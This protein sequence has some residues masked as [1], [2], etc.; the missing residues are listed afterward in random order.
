MSDRLPTSASN[1]HRRINCP[2]SERA[3]IGL[4]NEDTEFSLQ[5]TRLHKLFEL[6]K[7]EFEAVEGVAEDELN[8]VTFA[9]NLAQ[10]AFLAIVKNYGIAD[11][12]PYEQGTERELWVHVGFK[13]AI[14]GHCDIWRYYPGRKLLVILD[15]KFGFIEVDAAPV[16][17][18]LRTYAI[19]GSEEW[20]VEDCAVG[21]IQPRAPL[22]DGAEKITLAT[23]TR[24]SIAEA[25][26]QLLAYREAWMEKNAPIIPSP[27]ACRY[28]KAVTVCK[29]YLTRLS[30]DSKLPEGILASV[31]AMDSDTLTRF[32]TAVQLAS[33]EK[34]QDAIKGEMRKRVGAGLI[35]G[36][37]LK[38]NS[39]RT[40]IT[41]HPKALALAYDLVGWDGV[42]AAAKLS[43]GELAKT[44][45]RKSKTLPKPD[46]LTE[47]KAK[48][49]VA[50]KL[51]AVI[52]MK[53]P[54]PSVV[55][56]EKPQKLIAIEEE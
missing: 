41:D 3:E 53:T 43:T 55:P 34:V 37:R 38:E 32:F 39:P 25:K 42:Q 54:E 29:P 15:A 31:A 48:K 13:K 16:N 45:A 26:A 7:A 23:Y 5:G 10:K 17:W 33:N 9:R 47:D 50:S 28:C 35:P 20:D 24:E 40:N 27:S 21:I 22:H 18:Q 14:P 4:P 6:P 52:E 8:L 51:S 49:V 19:G 11:S 12:E 1:V 30:P 56:D 2:G 44:L 36:Y 46:Q